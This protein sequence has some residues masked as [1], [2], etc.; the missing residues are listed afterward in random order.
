[1]SNKTKETMK[2]WYRGFCDVVI[3]ALV[4]VGFS[5]IWENCLNQLQYREYLNKGNLLMVLLYG[6]L[7]VLFFYAFGGYK[8]G[9]NRI[10]NVILSQSLG[11][12]CVNVIEIIVTILMVGQVDHLGSIFTAYVRLAFFQLVVLSVCSVV[13]ITLYRKIFPPYRMLQIYGEYTNNL[14][15]KMNAREDKYIIAGEISCFEPLEQIDRT[16][17]QYDAVLINDVPSELRNKILKSCFSQRKRV[18]FTPKIS[19]II[20][21]SSDELK[22]FDTPVYFCRNLGMSLSQR[23]VKRIGDILISGIGIVLTSPIM[24]ITALAVHFYDGGPALYRQTRCT[25]GGREFEILKFRS[26]ITN[27]EE[28][29]QAR[30][31]AE[32]DKRITPV[33]RFIRAT[34]IDELPQFFN[35]L[36]G[37][38]SVVGP[39]PERPEINREYCEEVPEFAY[40]LYVKAGL[41]G[42]AQVFGKYNTTSYDKLKLDMIYVQNCSLFLDI[43]LIILTLKVIFQRESTEGLDDGSTTATTGNMKK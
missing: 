5:W 38:M 24:A 23:T 26:M 20:I 7:T 19:D 1:M 39:R 8:I 3:T 17:E 35:I 32:N 15:G 12:I 29:G 21:K 22:L 4:T 18:Y 6:V 34:R 11:I 9:V 25:I 30:L 40:R 16:I 13:M 41:T 10:S 43:Q 42:Y 27:A 31:A 33:G 36:R 37:D 14:A 2:Y 28:D